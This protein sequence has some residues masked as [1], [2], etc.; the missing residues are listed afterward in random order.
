ME[1]PTLSLSTC[2]LAPQA[3]IRASGGQFFLNLLTRAYAGLL[4]RAIARVKPTLKRTVARRGLAHRGQCNLASVV[5]V[6]NLPLCEAIDQNDDAGNE[7][8]NE[9]ED[10]VRAHISVKDKGGLLQCDSF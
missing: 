6:Q 8:D 1:L 2:C 3:G 5:S 9:N 10:N 4:K 7:N